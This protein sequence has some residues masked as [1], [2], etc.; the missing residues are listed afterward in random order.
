[1]ER[2]TPNVQSVLSFF[3]PFCLQ[4][5]PHLADESR[6]FG[7]FFVPPMEHAFHVLSY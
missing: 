6:D 5:R 7:D 1:M 2:A 3:H 4:G